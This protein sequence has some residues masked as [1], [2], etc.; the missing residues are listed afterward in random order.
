M[1][2]TVVP[3]A[4]LNRLFDQLDKLIAFRKD[5]ISLPSSSVTKVD[6]AINAKLHDVYH[7]VVK[8][9]PLSDFKVFLRS[10]KNVRQRLK[11]TYISTSST[12]DAKISDLFVEIAL[13]AENL[14]PDIGGSASRVGTS[15]NTLAIRY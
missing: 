10:Y 11:E 12:L 5:V 4:D 6:N 15:L 13:K 14:Q 1:S 9:P 3:R 8:L 2:S 7:V